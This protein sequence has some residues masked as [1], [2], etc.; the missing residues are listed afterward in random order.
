[1]NKN[2]IKIG[3]PYITSKIYH[4]RV[5]LDPILTKLSSPQKHHNPDKTN[6]I[7]D[8]NN[9]TKVD[10]D[11]EWELEL[12]GLGSMEIISKETISNPHIIPYITSQFLENKTKNNKSKL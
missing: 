9:A 1:M 4:Y 11:K 10:D 5:H 7:L 2:I 12:Y 6:P 8:N 3:D